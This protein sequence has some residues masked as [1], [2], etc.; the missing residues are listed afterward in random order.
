VNRTRAD[1]V[2]SKWGEVSTKKDSPIYFW[3][4]M[5]VLFVLGVGFLLIG[6]LKTYRLLAQ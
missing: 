2:T 1:F 5:S 3:F 4:S 6:L